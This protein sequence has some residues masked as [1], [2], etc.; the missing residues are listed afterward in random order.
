[1]KKSVIII[2]AFLLASALPTVCKEEKSLWIDFK[3]VAAHVQEKADQAWGHLA[4]FFHL[5]HKTQ[6]HHEAIAAKHEAITHNA[7]VKPEDKDAQK[8]HKESTKIV[9]KHDPAKHVEKAEKEVDKTKKAVHK[10]KEAHAELKV[11]V[12]KE[13]AKA[14]PQKTE[15]QM[16]SPFSSLN[17]PST[18]REMIE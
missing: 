15:V 11:A 9:T 4:A 5:H 6:I 17:I 8:D 2:F 16:L 18:N 13:A 12:A 1:M 7:I 3:E 14:E 10:A